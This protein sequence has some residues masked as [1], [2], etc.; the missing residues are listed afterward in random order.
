MVRNKNKKNRLGILAIHNVDNYGA[1]LTTFAI[2]KY[3]N[4]FNDAKII[5]FQNP[6]F[7]SHLKLIRYNGL[8]SWKSVL[9]DLFRLNHRYR[10]LNKFK[11]FIKKNLKLTKPVNL[12]YM[13]SN[14]FLRNFDTLV[15]SSD[16]VWNPNITHFDKK[17]RNDY[18]LNTT[19]NRK[20][21]KLSYASSFGSR[22][23]NKPEIHK[24]NSYL[25]NLD[26]IS[27]REKSS[28]KIINKKN[29][30]KTHHTIDP[31]FLID[32]KFWESKALNKK[33]LKDKN[34]ILVYS[35]ARSK[36]IKKTVRDLNKKL[37][38][39]VITIDP[40][41]FANCEYDKKISDA[42]LEEFLYYFKNSSFIVTDSFHGVCFSLIFE[43]KFLAVI[44]EKLY[45]N[46]LVEL[47]TYID[48]KKNIH[49]NNSR[50]KDINNYEISK[51]S[52]KKIYKFI[53]KS[54][55][56]LRDALKN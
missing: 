27:I 51:N 52:K 30:K 37:D 45:E 38:L 23:F 3:L 5:N 16:Q 56:Y 40:N 46:R 1:I 50:I 24:I 15:V 21:N 17:L 25:N 53:L 42:G 48:C 18:F 34:F 36:L 47:L 2:H 20:L 43:K 22:R 28:L 54:K 35:V 29:L 11:N 14:L 39:K 55:N 44:S 19:I 8:S 31:V 10:L 33:N 41:L 49:K 6:V 26:S 9:K 13:Y 12:N 4:K 32:K 7:S